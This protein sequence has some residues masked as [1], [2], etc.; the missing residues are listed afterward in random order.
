MRVLGAR[1]EQEYASGHIPGAIWLEWQ[2][3]LADSTM[4]VFK[5]PEE[6]A[7]LFAHA[8]VSPGNTAITYCAVGLRASVLYFAAKYAGLDARD[9]VGSWSDWQ[10]KGLPVER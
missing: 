8:G 6:L 5:K 10:R 9:Y 1:T 7:A 4:L 3:V 2:K